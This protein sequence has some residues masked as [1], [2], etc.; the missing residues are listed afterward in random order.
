VG[1]HNGSTA[2]APTAT[3]EEEMAHVFCVFDANDDGRISWS[4]L[5]ALFV[6]PRF[7]PA[8]TVE[9]LLPLPF[10]SS[11]HHRIPTRGTS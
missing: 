5:A 1:V 8:P 6:S 4:E 3:A 11:L 7:R 10:R 9:H 2:R